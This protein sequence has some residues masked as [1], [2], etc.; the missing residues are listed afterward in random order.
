MT[1][2][3]KY[4]YIMVKVKTADLTRKGSAADSVLAWLN[5][6]SIAPIRGLCY[7]LFV[8]QHLTPWLSFLVALYFPVPDENKV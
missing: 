8:I 2:W 5:V 4:D 7:E 1:E 6:S 3:A